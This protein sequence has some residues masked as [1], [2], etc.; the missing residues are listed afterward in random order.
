[1]PTILV[2][3][4]EAS[5][6]VHLEELRKMLP[7]DY[8]FI[9]VFEGKGA[10]YSPREFSIMGFRDVIGRLG[11]LL[12]A[13]REMAELAKSADMVLLMDASSFNIPLAKKIKKRD[14]S[15]KIMY[16]ILP[17]VWAWK[18]WRA[19]SIEKNC[20]FLGAILPFETS[21]Y[22]KKAQYVGHPLLDEIKCY[23]KDIKGNSVVF[24][25]GS[26]KSEIAK[27]FPLFVEVAKILERN[28]GLKRRV[29]VVPSF[30]KGLDLKA[31][32][33]KE[34]ECFEISYDAHKSLYEAEFAFICSGTATLEATLIGTP[35]VL[36]YRAKTIDFLIARMFVKL[37]YIGLANIFYNALNN[38]TPGLGESQLHPELIQHFL[39]VESL[40]RAY[41][42]MDRERY[43]KE[44][45]RLRE[46]LVSG[47]ARKVAKEIAF[48]LN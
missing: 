7:K 18:K 41:K 31:L 28:E 46:Y 32:Y 27:M 37:H 33:G 9:G 14:P 3:A 8:R 2:S 36:A 40:L 10:L 34:I 23:K 21:Y 20:D 5:S 16:Y 12:K 17:Q 26:R 6:N 35:F 39:S 22:Q 48:M 44:S 4:L 24:M 15:K 42:D 1:M 47:S 45:L 29:L 38:E 19:K 25:P 43:F 13:H 30:F 11:F